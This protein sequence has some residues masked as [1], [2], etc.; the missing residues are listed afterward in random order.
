MLTRTQAD[1]PS[2]NISELIEKLKQHEKS[3]A[4][5]TSTIEEKDAHIATL[6]EAADDWKRKYEFLSTDEPDSYKS[7]AHE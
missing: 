1:Q 7:L 6:T 5:L 4:R 3:I 2:T